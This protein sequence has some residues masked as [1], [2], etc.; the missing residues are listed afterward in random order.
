MKLEVNIEKKYAYTILGL[1][2]II[3]GIVAVNAYGTNNPPIFG[4]SIN[5]IEGAV[6]TSILGCS[7]SPPTGMNSKDF[8]CGASSVQTPE[9]VIVS[10]DSITLGGVSKTS[11]SSGQL[12]CIMKMTPLNDVAHGDKGTSVSCP[13]GYLATGGGYEGEGG[14]YIA[15]RPEPK[16]D[17]SPT[18]WW[19]HRESPGSDPENTNGQCIVMCCKI[20]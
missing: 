19:C 4:H 11:W 2:L 5:E 14:D 7:I 8:V 9:G 6:R 16:Y 18:Q 20:E 1:L 12:K 10:G 3:I 17:P 15:T 13:D